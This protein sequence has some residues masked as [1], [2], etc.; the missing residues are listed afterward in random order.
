MKRKV[1]LGI[2]ALCVLSIVIYLALELSK[3][4]IQNKFGNEIQYG[5]KS[6]NNEFID[7]IGLKQLKLKLQPKDQDHFQNLRE[8]IY[9]QDF[10]NYQTSKMP[11]WNTIQKRLTFKLKFTEEPLQIIRLKNLFLIGSN[12]Q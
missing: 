9:N 1:F 11:P 3:D 7:S 2:L 10:D 12:H 8:L 4:K 6:E 5:L